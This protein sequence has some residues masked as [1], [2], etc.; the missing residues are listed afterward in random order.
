MVLCAEIMH[1]KI[2][3]TAKSS[4]ESV[5][6]RHGFNHFEPLFMTDEARVEDDASERGARAGGAPRLATEC[7]VDDDILASASLCLK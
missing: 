1:L 6:G 5:T 4:A 7:I 3:I 2:A